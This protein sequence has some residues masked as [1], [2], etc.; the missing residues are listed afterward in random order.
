MTGTHV[1]IEVVGLVQLVRLCLFVIKPALE[2][3]S[4][5]FGQYLIALLNLAELELKGVDLIMED[6][7]RR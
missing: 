6:L 3:F 4:V 7:G 1:L 5:I 2:K